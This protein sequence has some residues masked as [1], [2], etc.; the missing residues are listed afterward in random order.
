MHV[1]D[2]QIYKINNVHK[3]SVKLPEWDAAIIT[4][5]WFDFWKNSSKV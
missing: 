5:T 2:V 4:S 1:C 3:M